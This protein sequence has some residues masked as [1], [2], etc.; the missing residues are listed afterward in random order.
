[1][2]FFLSQNFMLKYKGNV[3]C[4]YVF[5]QRKSKKNEALVESC[6]NS[7]SSHC[8]GFSSFYPFF[9]PICYRNIFFPRSV[10]CIIK[11]SGV[12]FWIVSFFG[13]RN[14]TLYNNCCDIIMCDFNDIEKNKSQGFFLR[15]F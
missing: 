7:S 14:F 15:M 6:F 4:Y 10:F 5:R 9:L 12:Y 8:R 2:T 13:Y 3:R 11:Y 1:M